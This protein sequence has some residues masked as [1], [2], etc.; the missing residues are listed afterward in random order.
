MK[1]LPHLKEKCLELAKKY[2]QHNDEIQGLIE[3]AETEIG[4]YG[5]PAQSEWEKCYNDVVEL[6]GENVPRKTYYI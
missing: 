2:P 4:H 3:L 5:E 6:T 1:R